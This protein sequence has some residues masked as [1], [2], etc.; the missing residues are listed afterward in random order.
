[1]KWCGNRLVVWA[2]WLSGLDDGACLL[3]FSQ[4]NLQRD[5]EALRQLLSDKEAV[6]Q[7]KLKTIEASHREAASPAATPQLVSMI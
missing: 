4:S 3:C 2:V 5:I 7:S 1:M 6:Y